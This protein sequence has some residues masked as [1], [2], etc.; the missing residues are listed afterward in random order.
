MRADR[1]RLFRS[2][3]RDRL[4]QAY[5]AICLNVG[6]AYVKYTQPADEDVGRGRERRGG[7]GGGPG[8]RTS[9]GEGLDHTRP[10][11]GRSR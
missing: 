3:V 7:G 11:S 10:S 4:R 2:M 6:R 9:A 5:F 1:R 8:H